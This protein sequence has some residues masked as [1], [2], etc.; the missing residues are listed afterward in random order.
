[1]EVKPGL[2]RRRGIAKWTR[3]MAFNTSAR[4]GFQF[5][6]AGIYLTR[7]WCN[8][9]GKCF[10]AIK[11]SKQDPKMGRYSRNDGIVTD[12]TTGG[13]LVGGSTPPIPILRPTP[14]PSTFPRPIAPLRSAL[15]GR[16]FLQETNRPSIFLEDNQKKFCEHQFFKEFLDT[17]KF[18]KTKLA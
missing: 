6:L 4:W 3:S 8:A 2:M 15:L 12:G 16:F 5:R 7:N 14:V 17:L 13:W 10:A 1:M 18:N 11:K 9:F